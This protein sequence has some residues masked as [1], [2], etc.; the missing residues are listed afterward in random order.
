VL[1]RVDN[2][3]RKGTQE[4][5]TVG[6]ACAGQ[7][8]QSGRE[9]DEDERSVTHDDCLGMGTMECSGVGEAL[10][11]A[12]LVAPFIFSEKF[13]L[14]RRRRLLTRHGGGFNLPLCLTLRFTQA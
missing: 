12:G 2:I 11:E 3:F 5:L 7:A 6:S 14:L 1:E 9:D 8:E 10:W 13:S 4:A